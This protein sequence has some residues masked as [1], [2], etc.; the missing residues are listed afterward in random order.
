MI[1]ICL[2]I[3]LHFF[4]GGMGVFGIEALKMNIFMLLLAT[5]QVAAKFSNNQLEEGVSRE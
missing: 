2:V 3:M 1:S 4:L 5:I